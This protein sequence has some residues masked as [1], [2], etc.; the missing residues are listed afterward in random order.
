[1]SKNK[2]KKGTIWTVLT[3]VLAVLTLVSAVAIPVTGYFATA[4]NVSLGAATQ[5]VIP[6]PDARF[7]FGATTKMKTT[8]WLT[9]SSC[10]VTL[11]QKVLPFW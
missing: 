3:I 2:Q 11:R 5:K 8:W 1:M 6:D 10:A 9:K 4:I 7:S